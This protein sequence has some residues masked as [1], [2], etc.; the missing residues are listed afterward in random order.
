MGGITLLAGIVALALG[1]RQWREPGIHKVFALVLAA[2]GLALLV[3][4][5][6]SWAEYQKPTGLV[7]LALVALG[8]ASLAAGRTQRTQARP[9]RLLGLSLYVTGSLL[10]V[11]GMIGF[12]IGY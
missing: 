8:I 6:S 3:V 4:T 10:A 2:V 11:G 7:P 5:I 1:R 12:Y 9:R